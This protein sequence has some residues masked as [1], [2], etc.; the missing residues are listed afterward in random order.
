MDPLAYV[1]L[2]EQA[3]SQSNS[4]YLVVVYGEFVSLLGRFRQWYYW[5]S[6]YDVRLPDKLNKEA[7]WE[8]C[9]SLS[10]IF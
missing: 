6:E 8:R 1:P 4:V 5:K 7:Y 10:P 3:S 9:L 2:L